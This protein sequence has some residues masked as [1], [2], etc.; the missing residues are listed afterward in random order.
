MRRLCPWNSPGQNTGVGSHSLLQG[1]FPMQWSNPGLPRCRRILYSLSHQGSPVN[2]VNI[3]QT[4][5][6]MTQRPSPVTQQK[7]RPNAGTGEPHWITV[8]A[9]SEGLS[10]RSISDVSATC[11]RFGLAYFLWTASPKARSRRGIHRGALLVKVTNERIIH[12]WREALVN[13]MNSIGALFLL[14][15][16]DL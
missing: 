6:V 14:Q 1:I 11:M 10:N 5:T 7:L 4:P 2:S 15:S 8:A 13:L 12:I 9:A 16:E 3:S